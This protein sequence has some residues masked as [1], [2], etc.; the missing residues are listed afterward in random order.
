MRLTRDAVIQ[1]ASELVDETG[2]HRISLKIIAEKL[3]IRTPSL[4]NHIDSLDDLLREIAHQGMATMNHNMAQAA[5]GISGDAAL[6][7][8]AVV[9]LNY[10]IQH[11]GVYETIQ[12]ATWNG[13]TETERLL[14]DYLAFLAR[15]IQSCHFQK[16]KTQEIQKILTGVLHGYVTL[17]LRLALVHPDEVRAGL[18]DTLDTVLLGLH[19]KY[20][21][22]TE[23]G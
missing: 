11:P 9:Y 20:D 12:W 6:Q 22:S 19:A 23:G 16:E 10:A 8:A 15:L 4:Y 17:Q 13:S 5:I 7:A 3:H 14:E 21:T 1:A 2:L 18:Y